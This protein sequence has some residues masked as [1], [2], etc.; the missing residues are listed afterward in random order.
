MIA[1]EWLRL[2][3]SSEATPPRCRSAETCSARQERASRRRIEKERE[4]YYYCRSCVFSLS[5]LPL[6]YYYYYHHYCWPARRARSGNEKLYRLASGVIIII[7]QV[8]GEFFSLLIHLVNSR[9]LRTNTH[10]STRP[11]TAASDWQATRPLMTVM[12][13]TTRYCCR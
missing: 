8:V 10:T 2:K 11:R 1:R 13:E 4:L 5:P 7:I 3:A 12:M 9:C 6:Y